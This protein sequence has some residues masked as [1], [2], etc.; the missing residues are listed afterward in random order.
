MGCR[1]ILMTSPTPFLDE[2][3]L[4]RARSRP[5]SR[6]GKILRQAH[7]EERDI[8]MFGARAFLNTEYGQSKMYFD[9]CAKLSNAIRAMK[10]N[11][12]IPDA[13]GP[14]AYRRLHELHERLEAA[15][16]YHNP[17]DPANRRAR[18]LADINKYHNM[19]CELV[20][21]L[22]R[23]QLDDISLEMLGLK[24]SDLVPPLQGP[25]GTLAEIQQRAARM[26]GAIS[27]W[28]SMSVTHRASEC[29]NVR[30]DRFE[31]RIARIEIALKTVL[32]AIR[33]MAPAAV[34]ATIEAEAK[35]AP[36]DPVVTDGDAA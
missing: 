2:T 8:S 6:E 11:I 26:A 27:T 3:S 29:T 19:I 30:F 36:V 13:N 18:E 7:R 22:M 32:D 21:Q 14:Y 1:E 28:S 12:E 25:V 5:N 4:R 16:N 9:E 10:P 31:N 23:M 34:P 20:P 33:K 24:V 15:A 17:N 35:P